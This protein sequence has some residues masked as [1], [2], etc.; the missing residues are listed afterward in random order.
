MQVSGAPGSHRSGAARAT[1]RQGRQ[2]RRVARDFEWKLTRNLQKTWK[3]SDRRSSRLQGRLSRET[4]NHISTHDHITWVSPPLPQRFS[5]H[6]NPSVLRV[7]LVHFGIVVTDRQGTPITVPQRRRLR[8]ASSAASHRSVKFFASADAASSARAA[9][10]VPPGRQR[11][12]G[13]RHQRS[14]HGG[15][16]VPEPERTGPST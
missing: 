15:H 9:S 16:Q 6:S 12:H 3:N 4:R 11:Q 8:S 13:E 5:W 7:N 2:P 10:R 1:S 14:P